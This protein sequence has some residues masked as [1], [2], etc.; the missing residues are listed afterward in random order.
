VGSATVLALGGDPVYVAPLLAAGIVLGLAVIGLVLPRL[1]AS[2]RWASLPVAIL[3]V[4][5]A[6]LQGWINV[7][8]GR[9]IG[10]WH[11]TDWAPIPPTSQ[12][13]ETIP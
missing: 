6:F 8:R 7:V 13:P 12:G 10:A 11:R 2:A 4:N 3:V 9:R 1:A 5:A